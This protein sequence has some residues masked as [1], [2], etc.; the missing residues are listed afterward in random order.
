MKVAVETLAR[1][2]DYTVPP[3]D[4]RI[5]HRRISTLPTSGFILSGIAR[6]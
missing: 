3:Q 4:L 2:I 5:S 6:R 1:T